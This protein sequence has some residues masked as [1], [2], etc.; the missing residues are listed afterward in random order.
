MRGPAAPFGRILSDAF[1][2]GR[3]VDAA[4]VTAPGIWLPY[5]PPFAP[6]TVLV[7]GLISARVPLGRHPV[8]SD[9]AAVTVTPPF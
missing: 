4:D 5:S 3:G 8:C 9:A 2:G 7:S 1:H 6:P